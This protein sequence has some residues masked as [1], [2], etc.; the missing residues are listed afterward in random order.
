VSKHNPESSWERLC[1]GQPRT[2]ATSVGRDGTC[3]KVPHTCLV[4]RTP[5]QE[6]VVLETTPHICIFFFS[7]SESSSTLERGQPSWTACSGCHLSRCPAATY[8]VTL[9]DS[10]AGLLPRFTLLLLHEFSMSL[11]CSQLGHCIGS[12]GLGSGGPKF[13][14][15]WVVPHSSLGPLLAF[16]FFFLA[17]LAFEL[18]TLNLLGSTLLLELSCFSY[19]RSGFRPGSSCLC[20]L[21]N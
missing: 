7:G 16:W 3:R 11:F 2:A 5:P 21:H 18:G 20:S 4:L 10:R 14:T 12:M 6:P 8:S 17:A 19:F 15:L 9:Q 13:C 1:P